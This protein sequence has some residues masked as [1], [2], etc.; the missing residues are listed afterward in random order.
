MLRHS[1][2]PVLLVWATLASRVPAQDTATTL[3]GTVRMNARS[4]SDAKVLLIDR[5]SKWEFATLTD[6][7]G[8][9]SFPQVPPGLYYLIVVGPLNSLASLDHIQVAL[10]TKSV[11]DVELGPFSPGGITGTGGAGDA[12]GAGSVGAGQ[13]N[14][15][16]IDGAGGDGT[17]RLTGREF[18]VQPLNEAAGYGLYSYVLFGSGPTDASRQRYESAIQAF[19]QVISDVNELAAEGVSRQRLNI[20]YLPIKQPVKTPPVA[21]EVLANY[22]FARS[23]A[24]LSK[25]SGGIR[26]GGPYVVS[27][28]KPLSG[29]SGLDKFLYQDLSSVPSTLIVPWINEFRVQASR[30][31]FWE[32]Q[33]MAQ[34]ALSLRTKIEIAAL[35]LPDVKAAALDWATLI[36]QK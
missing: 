14:G 11:V 33:T 2:I 1:L 7:N 12:G 13:S 29:L 21:A 3:S 27:T 34:L 24:L 28:L 30:D 35:A 6:V 5:A 23:E 16:L 15:A 4:V 26:T 36:V 9:Y 17:P 18:L 22:D 20:L 31:E 8:H 32:G 10:S 25:L 19:L